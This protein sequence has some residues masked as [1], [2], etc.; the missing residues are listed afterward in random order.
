MR[1]FNLELPKY[2]LQLHLKLIKRRKPLV[3]EPLMPTRALVK[4]KYR[5]GSL[6]GKLVRHI[7][8]HKSARKVIVSNMAA[9]VVVG[10]F[11]P[12]VQAQSTN[13][14]NQSSEPD[15][16]VIQTTN[17]LTTQ[18]AI[19]FPL[20]EVRVNQ[21]YSIFHP[22]VD[23]GANIGDPVKPIKAGDV[24]EADYTTDGYGNT[25]VIDHG[26]GLTSRYA[27]LSKIEVTNG[28]EVTTNT[29]IGLV[30]VTGHS[31]GPHL[32]LEILQNGAAL[33]PLL[34]LSR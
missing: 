23:L 27:H 8:E 34:V 16:T 25:I 6:I 11:L 32:H 17:I 33:N 19:Q 30:G 12:G 5:S 20:S 1:K 21:K 14:I 24:I 31:T 29:E 13:S 4:R 3:S 7:S 22:G 28:E 2:R 10:S 15:E 9:F 26:N 18:K